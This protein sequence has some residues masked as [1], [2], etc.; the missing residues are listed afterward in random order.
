MR[1]NSRWIKDLEIRPETL[2]LLEEGISPTLQHISMG[3]NFLNKTPKA[4]EIKTRI[5][6]GIAL[7]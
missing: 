2:K 1:V 6:M 3:K 4:Q 7:N 5:D